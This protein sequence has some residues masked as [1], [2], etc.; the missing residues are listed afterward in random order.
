MAWSVIT[1]L[2]SQGGLGILDP[3]EQSKALLAKLVVRSFLPREE[4][5]KML[6]RNRIA[7]CSPVVGCPW[8][9]DVRWI[10]NKKIKFRYARNREDKFVNGIWHA[11]ERMGT[12]L[13]CR[14]GSNRDELLRQPLLWNSRITTVDGQMVGTRTK[15]AWGPLAAGLGRSVKD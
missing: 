10:F 3:I 14:S 13:E 12:G 8:E 11:W 6:M 15:V 7:L 5:W 4:L 1:L 9:P 2:T